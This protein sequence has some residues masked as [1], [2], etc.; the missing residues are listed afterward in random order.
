MVPKHWVWLTGL[1]VALAAPSVFSQHREV[2]DV[3]LG[4]ALGYNMAPD[5]ED[6][7]QKIFDE[8][9][10]QEGVASVS[11]EDG[12]FGWSAYGGYFLADSLA[13]EL[14]YL[15]NADMDVKV[16]A[17][18]YEIVNSDVSTS[19]FYAA[20]VAYIPMSD[21]A[22]VF[23]FFKGGL[24]RWESETSY[25]ILGVTGTEDD[26]GTNLLLGAGVDVPVGDKASIRGEY[27]MLVLDDDDGGS[28]HRFQVGVNFAF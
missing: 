12:V 6:E 16:R 19:V 14:G 25:N 20:A 5:A 8:G 21:G 17:V 4:A 11:V 22:A 23:P 10:G 24:F 13:L 15:G 18:G 28:H 7:V 2:G 3:Y 27:M 1:C 9:I 26:D